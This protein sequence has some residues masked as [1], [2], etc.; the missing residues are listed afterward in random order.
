MFVAELQ[1]FVEYC[2]FGDVG[3]QG[4]SDHVELYFH[5]CESPEHRAGQCPFKDVACH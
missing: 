3:K 4:A 2:K 1:S 5:C